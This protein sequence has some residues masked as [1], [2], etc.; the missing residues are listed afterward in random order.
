MNEK[1]VLGLDRGQK[2]F[3]CEISKFSV[4]EPKSNIGYD[5]NTNRTQMRPC[6]SGCM[7]VCECWVEMNFI[8]TNC[9]RTDL[10][11][12]LQCILFLTR[13]HA[14]AQSWPNGHSFKHV[15]YLQKFNIN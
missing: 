6:V 8:C 13:S 9:E 15:D 3:S 10:R 12:M 7:C 1:S 14:M 4:V 2:S 5:F 11:F